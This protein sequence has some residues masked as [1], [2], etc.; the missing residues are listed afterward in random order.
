MFS[1]GNQ[2]IHFKAGIAF[3]LNGLSAAFVDEAIFLRRRLHKVQR[4]L[5][6][7]VRQLI[8]H[9][10]RNIAAVFQLAQMRHGDTDRTADLFEGVALLLSDLTPLFADELLGV[11]HFFLLLHVRFQRAGSWGWQQHFDRLRTH[12][13]VDG[14]FLDFL[15]CFNVI[16]RKDPVVAGRTLGGDHPVLFPVS[17]RGR[18]DAENFC[19]LIDGKCYFIF[20]IHK[21]HSLSGDLDFCVQMQY[22]RFSLIVGGFAGKVKQRQ[23]AH[24]RKIC[25]GWSKREDKKAQEILMRA[26]TA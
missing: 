15:E 19:N 1:H 4:A 11:K 8:E 7:E 20:M 16:E 21:F 3:K 23:T 10:Q 5:P 13:L 17:D 25:D 22:D 9:I 2:R 12:V 18:D 26:S 14:V 6:I 24:R